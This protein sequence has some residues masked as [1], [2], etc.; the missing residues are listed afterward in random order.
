MAKGKVL[1]IGGFELPDKNAAAQR[2]LSVGKALREI[3]YKVFYLGITHDG[4]ING[5]VE[6]MLYENISYPS[7]TWQW[8][9][10]SL[11]IKVL[12]TIKKHNPSIIILYNYPSFAQAKIIKYCRRNRIK[13]IGDITE[14]Y[15]P[16]GILRKTDTFLRMRYVN[17]QLDGIIAISKYLYN[18]YHSQ[19]TMYLP[20]LVHLEEP[21]W[22]GKEETDICNSIKLVYIGSPGKKDRLDYIIDALEKV[23]SNRLVL[24]I[25]GIT[26]EQYMDLYGKKGVEDKRIN[27]RGRLQHK[28]AIAILKTAD[29][30]LFF[31]DNSRVNN[32]GF[33]T[34]FVESVSAGVAVVTNNISNVSD[35][36]INGVNGYMCD[37]FSID[38]LV[39]VLNQIVLLPKEEIELM[40]L[41]NK[42]ISFDYR[43]FIKEIDCFIN[44]I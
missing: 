20:P 21:K 13:I 22:V 10:Y 1:Y 6:G 24:E 15:A 44:K 5:E 27:F 41:N 43:N 31:R 11:G 3:G 19:H 40:K 35:Y 34:K 4:V 29:Y 30:Q 17:K 18:F 38:C 8:I 37:S 14:W 26:K 2:V 16:K 28:D 9:K 33:P 23:S 32:A 7:S 12:D 39:D 36:L 25:I 42:K